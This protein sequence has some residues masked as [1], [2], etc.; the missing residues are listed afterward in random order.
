MKLI[1]GQ[2]AP[3]GPQEAESRRPRTR[4]KKILV[5]DP[6]SERTPTLLASLEHSDFETTAAEGCLHALTMLEWQRPD[7]I[8]V[9]SEV[10]DMSPADFCRTVRQDPLFNKVPAALIG[11]ADG[12]DAFDLVL[13]A[14][15]ADRVT[16]QV[17]ELL[18]RGLEVASTKPPATDEDTTLDQDLRRKIASLEQA[19]STGLLHVESAGHLDP[20]FLLFDHGQLVHAELGRLHGPMALDRIL[21]D[22]DRATSMKYRFEELP[23]WKITAYPR[24]IRRAE[25]RKSLNACLDPAFDTRATRE[26]DL[27]A[28]KAGN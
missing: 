27:D 7:L 20:H 11:S 3:T 28:W 5:V 18:W 6:S 12:Q 8:L 10:K 9:H 23:R 13:E 14:G 24:S 21:I 2:D 19:T 16:T 1:R 4:L 22:A 25:S 26:I 15:D 17:C